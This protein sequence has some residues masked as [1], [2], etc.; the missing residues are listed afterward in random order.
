MNKIYSMPFS[1][2]SY[3]RLT[4]TDRK[5]LS[6]L[7]G[8][9]I[10]KE[11]LELFIYL[12]DLIT[13]D[14]IESQLESHTKLFVKLNIDNFENFNI[15]KEKLEAASLLS[16]YKNDSL[17]IY[18][19][20]DILKPVEFFDDIL[21]ATMLRQTIGVIEFE[22]LQRDLLVTSYDLNDFQNITKKQEDFLLLT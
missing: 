3:N 14:D 13:H 2:I 6:K 12:H 19:L 5:L 22:N 11:A 8:P 17:T 15:I 18:V 4:S 10:G 20:H 7:Y 16:T 21:L 1:V 9:F